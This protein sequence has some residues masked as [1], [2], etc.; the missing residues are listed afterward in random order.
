MAVD[1]LLPSRVIFAGCEMVLGRVVFFWIISWFVIWNFRAQE[2]AIRKCAL[3][4]T[5]L[6]DT[7]MKATKSTRIYLPHGIANA[8]LSCKYRS[9]HLA[10]F[11]Y[12]GPRPTAMRP[13]RSR[14]WFQY[15]VCN[16]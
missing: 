8:R 1:T 2:L 15:R 6:D 3:Q 13:R 12:V 4:A 14:Q 11:V 16:L 7:K 5:T 10:R 9:V